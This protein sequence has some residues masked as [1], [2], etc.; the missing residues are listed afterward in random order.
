MD[1]LPRNS[2]HGV[3][4]EP[5][6]IEGVTVNKV[7][8][9]QKPMGK[10]FF[11]TFFSGDNAQG[12]FEYIVFDVIIPAVKDLASDAWSQLGERALYGG[13]SRSPH[14]RANSRPSGTSGYISYNRFSTS[15]RPDDRPPLPRRAQSN[16]D[17]LVFQTR[18]EALEVLD[19]MNDVIEKYGVVT[20]ADVYEMAELTPEPI[21]HK[22]GW[23]DL[24]GSRVTKIREG[25]LIQIPRK[26]E[27][28]N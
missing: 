13:E 3:P 2:N 5:K 4:Q 23:S 19:Q 10:R 15:Q 8:R 24:T 11:E 1:S 20:Q 22:W 21:D 18:A 6:K 25:H 12:V 28:I 9:R 14:R 7:T 16:F 17:D 26:P 27:P